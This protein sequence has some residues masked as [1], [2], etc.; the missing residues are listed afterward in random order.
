MSGSPPSTPR[1]VVTALALA[2][3]TAP[4]SAAAAVPAA[5]NPVLAGSGDRWLLVAVIALL[6]LVIAG[7]VAVALVLRR[8]PRA[9]PASPPV[10]RSP[11][12]V[13]PVP[14]LPRARPR[15]QQV[16]SGGG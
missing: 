16:R 15:P 4:G 14:A 12:A 1:P 13:P 8:R 5:V 10:A 9:Q 6:I 3:L 11:A 2:L 7:L